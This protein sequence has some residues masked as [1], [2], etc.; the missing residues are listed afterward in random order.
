MTKLFLLLLTLIAVS[1][2]A[3][4]LTYFSK[5]QNPQSVL[6]QYNTYGNANPFQLKSFQNPYH[7]FWNPYDKNSVYNDPRKNSFPVINYNGSYHGH[8]GQYL[9]IQQ[10]VTNPYGK[11]GNN[12]RDTHIGNP[13]RPYNPNNH[14]GQ[15]QSPFNQNSARNNPQYTT[16]FYDSHG[17]FLGFGPVQSYQNNSVV[18]PY[19]HSPFQPNNTANPY[20]QNKIL[21]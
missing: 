7:N 15:F 14:Y 12:F 5:D 1:Q 21:Q 10:G 11:Y 19:F 8:A 18:N 9:K 13:Y 2:Q 6:K 20:G 16:R 17:R 4:G 3:W